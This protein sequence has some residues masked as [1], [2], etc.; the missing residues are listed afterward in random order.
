MDIHSLG[1]AIAF[2][3]VIFFYIWIISLLLK[4]INGGSQ[5]WRAWAIFLLGMTSLTWLTRMNKINTFLAQNGVWAVPLFGISLCLFLA[6]YF[7]TEPKGRGVVIHEYDPPYNLLPGE[8]SFLMEQR[9]SHRL[10]VATILDLVRRGYLEL[11]FTKNKKTTYNNF[12]I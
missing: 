11:S 6:W 9:V 10:I 7:G 4:K 8:M 3:L 5:V 1:V 2:F 12:Y